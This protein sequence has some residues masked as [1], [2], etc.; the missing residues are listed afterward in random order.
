MRIISKLIPSSSWKLVIS[1]IGIMALVVFS[2]LMLVEAQSLSVNLTVDGEKQN[3]K[4]HA[5]TV[6][7]LLEE[8]DIT[9]GE[10]DELS[11]SPDTALSD[12]MKEITLD[13]A[14]QVTVTIDGNKKV[15]FTTEDTIGT[16]L[17]AKDLAFSKHDDLSFDL[18]DP[19]KDGMELAIEKGF[20][21]TVND[22]GEKEELWTTGGKIKDFLQDNDITYDKDSDDTI[23][24]KLKKEIN[25]DTTITITRIE[26]LPDKVIEEAIPY[27][28]EEQKD[29]TLKKGKE[30]VLEEGKEGK[31]EKTYKVIKKNGEQKRTLDD[32]EVITESENR[33][34]AVGTKK[35]EPEPKPKKKSKPSKTNN[36]KPKDETK[37]NNSA[38]KEDGK[39]L[40]MEATAFT[41]NCSGCSG[42]TATG[43][44][45]NSNPN[46]KVIAVDPGVIPLGSKVWV[47]GY[48]EATAADTG[49]FSGN[50]IDVHVATEA[51]AS[52]FG[53]K[54]VKVK[55]LD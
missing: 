27:E 5:D 2:G 6:G 41:A 44:D 29:D 33:V 8:E 28:T 7:E 34:I 32:E 49:G 12:G 42:H 51:D 20:K 25:E 10:H 13:H 46:A 54:R 43:M 17:E 50:R 21:I 1:S 9:V 37:D 45:L 19:V 16:F 24:P 40:Y 4:T 30:K 52:S 31:K 55:I 48:G 22:G 35:P 39:V 36:A 47:E 26:K 18:E 23:K 3:V 14:K 15:F 38:D 53:R 11:H